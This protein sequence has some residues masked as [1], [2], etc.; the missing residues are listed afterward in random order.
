MK[1]WISQTEKSLLKTPIFEVLLSHCKAED[2]TKEFNF[3]L[4]K[5]HDWANII[6][7]T[8]DGNIVMVKQFR[9]GTGD[10]TLEFPGGVIDKEDAEP[11]NG[12]TRELIEETGYVPLPNARCLNLGWTHP[13]PAIQNNRCHSFAI[14]P[15]KKEREQNLDPGE[16]LSV[17]ELSPKEL[18][19]EITS[20][21]MTHALMLITAFLLIR[22][23][24]STQEGLLRELKALR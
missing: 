14:G 8:V 12:A 15:V 7:V 18:L 2:R 3:Y 17:V 1:K 24:L 16:L 21:R 6:P 4:L 5:T 22:N 19:A 9:V 20:G 13:N 10:Y 23:S 11:Q